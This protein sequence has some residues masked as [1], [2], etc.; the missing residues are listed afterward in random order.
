MAAKWLTSPAS[1]NMFIV[2]SWLYRLWRAAISYFFSNW[3][4]RRRRR[5]LGSIY[6][7]QINE[8]VPLTRATSRRPQRY[9]CQC[10]P[11][12][13]GIPVLPPE[14]WLTFVTSITGLSNVEAW[15]QRPGGALAWICDGGR[16]HN[17]QRPQSPN[18]PSPV[19]RHSGSELAELADRHRTTAQTQSHTEG[20]GTAA[21]EQDDWT[22]A[23]QRIGLTHWLTLRCCLHCRLALGGCL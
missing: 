2:K 12:T 22:T 14:T 17:Q 7:I 5:S 19:L 15:S 6:R 16:L 21:Q 11:P 8:D 18:F 1:R 13:S 10:L 20:Q 23:L 3:L 4:T 9:Q